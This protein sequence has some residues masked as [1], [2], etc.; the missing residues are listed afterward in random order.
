MQ[1]MPILIIRP[2]LIILK[3]FYTSKMYYGLKKAICPIHKLRI[4]RNGIVVKNVE[5]SGSLLLIFTKIFT[6][7]VGQKL[8]GTE[9]DKE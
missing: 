1:V 7:T 8:L 3:V 4:N 6:K 2:F 9:T 5:T